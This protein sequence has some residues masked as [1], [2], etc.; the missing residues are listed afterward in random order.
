MRSQ[1]NYQGAVG[2]SL[3]L[4]ASLWLQALLGAEVTYEVLHAFVPFRNGAGPAA[5]IH[6]TDGSFY[7]TIAGG[8]ANG[9]GT[10]F[11]YEPGVGLTTLHSFAG[12]DGQ[13]P[14]AALIQ[15]TDGSFYGTTTRGGQANAGV[16]FRLTVPLL[17]SGL[18]PGDCNADGTVNISDAICLLGHLFLGSPTMLPCGDGTRDD[19]ANRELLNWNGDAGT[20]LSDAVALLGRLFLGGPPHVLGSECR[21]IGSCPDVCKTP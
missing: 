11:K 5:L 6:G 3:L 10:I 14:Q 17:P 21:A 7:G 18:V 9:L 2:L 8:G 19:P 16:I 1:R 13:F 12:T 15:G 4:A 20:D